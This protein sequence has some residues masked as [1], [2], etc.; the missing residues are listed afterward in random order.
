MRDTS[1]DCI[2]GWGV[3][4][5]VRQVRNSW[6]A[7]WGEEGYVRMAQG[8]NLCNIAEQATY[9]TPTKSST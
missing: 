5:C 1:S 8:V 4:R 6:G 7:D 9:S 2:W 3:V